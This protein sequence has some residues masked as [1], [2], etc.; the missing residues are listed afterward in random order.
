M[1]QSPKKKPSKPY[2]PDFR[3]RAVRLAMEH[4]DEYLTQTLQAIVNS[5]KQSQIDGLL[6]W[7]YA[8]KV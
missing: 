4:R 3:E 8:A 6:P 7:N 5:H 2:S 1:E